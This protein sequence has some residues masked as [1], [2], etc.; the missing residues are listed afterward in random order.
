MVD[1]VNRSRR[2]RERLTRTEM[3]HARLGAHDQALLAYAACDD[4]DPARRLVVIVQ[5]RVVVVVPADR[6]GVHVLV[7]PDE[8]VR[9]HAARGADEVAPALAGRRELGR[10]GF[11]LDA[12][13]AHPGARASDSS[14]RAPFSARSASRP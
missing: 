9:A 3:A 4:G 11:E 5:A 8:L 1:A 14:S 2:D 10:E 12:A 7:R 13:Q 6:P